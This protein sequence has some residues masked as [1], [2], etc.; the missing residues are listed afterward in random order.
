[1]NAGVVDGPERVDLDHR[2]AFYL[3]HIPM[4]PMIRSHIDVPTYL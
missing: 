2:V 1:M 4:N 3:H